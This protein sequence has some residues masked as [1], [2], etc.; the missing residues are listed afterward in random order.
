MSKVSEVRGADYCLK[1][2]AV[3]AIELCDRVRRYVRTAMADNSSVKDCT[4]SAYEMHECAY[5]LEGF[6]HASFTLDDMIK[7]QKEVQSEHDDKKG[8]DSGKE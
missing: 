1:A 3:A 5:E 6:I 4:T 2:I 8:E 7:M